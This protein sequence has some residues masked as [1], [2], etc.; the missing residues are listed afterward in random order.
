MWPGGVPVGVPCGAV[1]ICVLQVVVC[2]L[3]E[4][5]EVSGDGLGVVVGVEGLAACL[6]DGG[7]SAGAAVAVFSNCC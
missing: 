1:V 6:F 5:F 3:S 7:L 4:L 2:C